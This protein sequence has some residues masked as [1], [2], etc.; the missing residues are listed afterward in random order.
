MVSLNTARIIFGT[1]RLETNIGVRAGA[2]RNVR[3]RLQAAIA[4]LLHGILRVVPV[5]TGRLYRSFRLR[6]RGNNLLYLRFTA[7]Y[8]RWPEVRSKRNR[9]YF[10]RG[11]RA[12][13]R[14]ANAIARGSYQFQIARNVSPTPSGGLSAT[15]RYLPSPGAIAPTTRRRTR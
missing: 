12:G 1:R 4:G 5:I 10:R 11:L 7:P 15:V 9:F 6:R 8:A 2:L 13:V 14:Q 3:G